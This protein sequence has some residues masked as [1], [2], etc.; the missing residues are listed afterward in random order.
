MIAFGRAVLKNR[1]C[2]KTSQDSPILG[3]RNQKTE[4]VGIFRNLLFGVSRM[5]DGDGG[6]VDRPK[7]F[8]Q[9]RIKIVY[10]FCCHQRWR[11]DHRRGKIFRSRVRLQRKAGSQPSNGRY[12][13]IKVN[14][15]S[16]PL[17]KCVGESLHAVLESDCS[18]C[19]LRQFRCWIFLRKQQSSYYAA[20]SLFELKKPRERVSDTQLIRI[21]RINTRNKCVDRPICDFPSKA[22]FEKLAHR[23]VLISRRS[24]ERLAKDPKFSAG[25]KDGACNERDGTGRQRLQFTIE[26]NITF[27]G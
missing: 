27:S 4:T 12:R 1:R 18:R 8:R 20:V 15:S 17:K 16:E 5:N 9:Y 24:Y 10:H 21:A 3:G 22:P 7:P 13:R 2:P 25:S 6:I 11:T 19:S 14:R 23:F 26:K